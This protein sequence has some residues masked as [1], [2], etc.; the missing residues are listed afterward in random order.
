MVEQ[1]AL[2][3]NLIQRVAFGD[4]L[5]RRARDAADT[6]A[7]ISYGEQGRKTIDYQTLNAKANQ[8][9]RG[10]RQ[11]GINQG[12]SV[13]LLATNS[14]EFFITLFACY[15]GGFIAVP[16]NFLQNVSDIHY[17]LTQAQV[18]AVV[19]ESR[20]MPLTKGAELTSITTYIAIDN[21]DQEL[22]LTSLM[23]QQD[24]SEINDVIINDRDTA[25]IIF[26]SG[27]TSKAK[28]IETSHLAITMAT[29]STPLGFNF[30]IAHRHLA[31][32]PTFHCAAL[33]FCLSTLQ[34]RG[35]LTLLPAF[36]APSVAKIMVAERIQSAGLLPIMWK[37]LLS[38][39]NLATYDHSHLETGIYA[40]A[41]M[42]SATLTT[43]R[44][45]FRGCRFHLGSGQ[46]EFTPVA[47]IYYDRCDTEFSEG[48]YWGVPT[49]LTEQAV[50]DDNGN[51]VAPGEKGEICWRGPQVMSGYLGDEKQSQQASEFGWHHSGDLGLV[52]N[53]GQLLFVDRKKDMIKSGG[54]NVA[55]IKVEQILLGAP[56]VLQV[57]VFGVPH[58]HWVEAVVGA[59]QLAPNSEFNEQDII[60]YCKTHLAGYE[61]PK[62]ILNLEQF[63]LTATGK[64]QKNELRQQYQ[65]LFE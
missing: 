43:L 58:Q 36:D 10:L 24:T 4:T 3:Q 2:E 29:L 12:D 9:V 35:T 27:T 20:F 57:A 62:R 41:P 51:E 34:I 38:L 47:C 46:S 56:N 60:D 28:G 32:L 8:L 39:D 5:R 63:P 30:A 31:V 33:T 44:E 37:A 15:K 49:L 52:D 6:T 21:V 53:Q 48:N 23:A 59:V 1:T 50:I 13:A 22:T 45:T 61:V 42:D 26:S 16:I 14:I 55:S 25:H 54:E 65:S 64:I 18:K 11:Q 17:N 7:I 19:A 40:M